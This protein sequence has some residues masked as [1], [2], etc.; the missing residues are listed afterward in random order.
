[1]LIYKDNWIPQ[2]ITF[3]PISLPTLP[4]ETTVSELITNDNR[5]KEALL[6]EHFMQEDADAI[7]NIPLPRNHSKDQ[8]IW[9]YDKNGE[10]SVKSGY[11][12]AP[13]LKVSNIPSS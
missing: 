3:K 2:P 8:V 9:H 11:Q 12:I 6:Y 13:K 1:M 5:W 10:Y 7:M 4:S